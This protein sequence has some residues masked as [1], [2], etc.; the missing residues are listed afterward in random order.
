[1]S[2]IERASD[3]RPWIVRARSWLS[4][5]IITPFALLAALSVPI[6]SEESI[7]D[8]LFDAAGWACFFAG[9]TFRWW[10]TMYVGGRKE[11]ELTVDGPY[12]V[13]R[14][15]LYLGTFLLTLS[16]AFFLHTLMFA[17]GLVIASQL[18]LLVT[19]PW[20][21]KRLLKKFGERYHAYRQRVPIFFPEFSKFQSPPTIQ[22]NLNG[23][24]GEFRIALRW[25]WIPLLA[26]AVAHLRTESWW[27]ALLRLP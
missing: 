2:T 8:F 18:Y 10:A 23:L 1:M 4:I 21:E 20:E 13:C 14:N 24:T 6:I 15:P 19:V 27:P 22:V 12:S 5:L 9:A 3:A 25:I 17:V 11:Q 26:E 7:V 16:I